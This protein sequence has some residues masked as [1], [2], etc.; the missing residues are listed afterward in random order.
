MFIIFDGERLD[1]IATIGGLD[2][3]DMDVLEVQVKYS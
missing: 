2:I 1:P 3:E